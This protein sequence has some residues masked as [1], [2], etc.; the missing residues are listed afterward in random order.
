MPEDPFVLAR[1]CPAGL[2][3]PAA[4]L[5]LLAV[6]GYPQGSLAQALVNGLAAAANGLVVT[7]IQAGITCFMVCVG[8]LLVVGAVFVTLILLL[9]WQRRE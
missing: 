4:V 3:L 7:G 1:A 5:T 6:M 2:W 9:W 8:S